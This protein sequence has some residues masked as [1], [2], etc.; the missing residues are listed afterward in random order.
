MSAMSCSREAAT[1]ELSSAASPATKREFF[2]AS[3]YSDMVGVMT[4]SAVNASWGVRLHAA[5]RE[6]RLG[7]P[8]RGLEQEEEVARLL[9][10]LPGGRADRERHRVLG[11]G[12]VA[13]RVDDDVEVGQ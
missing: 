3:K 4:T 9:V 1:N 5:R 7:T 10:G 11:I 6:S 13:A 8:Q 2:Q 12:L